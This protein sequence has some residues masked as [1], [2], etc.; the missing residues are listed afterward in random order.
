V[1]DGAGRQVL[2]FDSNYAALYL[3][4]DGNEGD[5]ILRNNAGDDT[6]KLDGN[7]G[8]IFVWRKISGTTREVFRFDASHA[9]MY[10]G[11]E[12]N[13]GDLFIRDANG[14]NVLRFDARFAVLDVGSTGN[15]GDIRVRDNDGDVRIHLDGGSGDIKLF[16]ADCAENF[17][18]DDGESFDEGTV[19]VIGGGGTLA[20]CNHEYDRTAAGVVSGGGGLQPGIVLG[21]RNDGRTRVPV[22]L[23]G[24]VFCKVDADHSP[25][26][27]GDLLTTSPTIG[28]AMRASDP[29][30]TPGAVIGKA[31]GSMQSG[32]G[33][34]PI[35]VALQ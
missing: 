28:H 33:L 14:E 19:L 18:V 30:R 20:A 34:V 6:M 11:S 22:A 26:E 21:S 9:A 17:E 5:L 1:R 13:E 23:L 2:H 8:D 31:M 3:G 35:L 24:R 25:V 7:E 10:I 12:G 16:G 15:E 32:R 4:N 27:I 29:H